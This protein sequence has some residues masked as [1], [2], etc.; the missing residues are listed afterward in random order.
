MLKIS[1]IGES[2]LAKPLDPELIDKFPIE[3]VRTLDA[4]QKV[5]NRHDVK[6]AP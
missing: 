5:V 6:V 3:M 2:G 4:F 1:P